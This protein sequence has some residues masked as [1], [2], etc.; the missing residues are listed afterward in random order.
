MGVSRMLRHSAWICWKDLLEFSRSKL[1]MVMLVL[2]PLFMM[3]MV[4]FIFPTGDS[5]SQQPVALANQDL[6]VNG[7]ALGDG[8]V[9]QLKAVNNQ[10]NLMDLREATGF[11]D[12]RTMIQEGKVSGGI[13]VPPTFTSDILAGR[14]GN[15]TIMTD[16]SNPQMS[17]MIQS[18]L[19]QVIEQL[20]PQMAGLNLNQTYGVSLD[21]TPAVLMPY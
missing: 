4:G 18:V 21:Q 19:T 20:G 11:D 10:T 8:L 14:Q 7:T 2:M 6:A 17:V 12:I 13:I 5:I 1:K 16:Q 15:I 3:M 9:T